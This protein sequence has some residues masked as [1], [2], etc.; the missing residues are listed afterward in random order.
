MV[1]ELHP[2]TYARHYS[3]ETFQMTILCG[4]KKIP[5]RLNPLRPDRVRRYDCAERILRREGILRF[6]RIN[7]FRF[8]AASVGEFLARAWK[9]IDANQFYSAKSRLLWRSVPQPS[10]RR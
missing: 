8:S 9:L 3:T 4:Q 6:Y 10:Q 5:Y 2:L 7:G 1:E